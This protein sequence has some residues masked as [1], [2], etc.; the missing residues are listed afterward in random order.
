[1]CLLVFA[2][3]RGIAALAALLAERRRGNGPPTPRDDDLILAA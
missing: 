3:A 1:M 2:L